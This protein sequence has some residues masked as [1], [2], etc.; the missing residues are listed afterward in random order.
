MVVPE[1]RGPGN[2]NPAPSEKLPP[3]LQA[4]LS[5]CAGVLTLLYLH[6]ARAT[7]PHPVRTILP[8][9]GMDTIPRGYR[10]LL[11]K[12]NALADHG[13]CEVR[14]VNGIKCFQLSPA[15]TGRVPT[16]RLLARK[17]LNLLAAHAGGLK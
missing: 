8:E 3:S 12:L 17:F 13:I 7:G 2:R 1:Q 14:W 15:G 5:S 10:L 11:P 6:D 16:A 4:W 9:V